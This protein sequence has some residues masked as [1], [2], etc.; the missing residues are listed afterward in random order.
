MLAKFKNLSVAVKLNLLLGTT[1][2]VVIVAATLWVSSNVR[3]QLEKQALIEL[4]KTNAMVVSMFEAYNRSLTADI[5]RTG[6]LFAD[7][8][9]G[10]IELQGNSGKPVLL[11]NGKSF[12]EQADRIDVFSASSGSVATV[13]ARQSDD[14]IRIAT[15]IKKDDGSRATGTPLAA[16][17]P[18]RSLLLAG[19]SYTGKANLFGKDYITHYR[20][21]KGGDGKVIGAFFV[22]FDLTT[23]LQALKKEILTTKI[24]ETGYIFAL[25]AGKDKGM[26]T[27]HPSL[28]GTNVLGSKDNNG[29]EFIREIV[30]T[31]AGTIRYDWANKDEKTARAKVV[32]FTR[33]AP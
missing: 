12:E 18:A 27:V 14:F 25:D 10:T 28:E 16:D 31:P 21:I 8:L 30:E 23:G 15:S 26:I 32:V 4:E 1:L 33:F 9:G 3:Q 6:R 5:E 19:N 17:H 24:G 13:F 11:L 7:S 2:L 22:G 29:R 20:P